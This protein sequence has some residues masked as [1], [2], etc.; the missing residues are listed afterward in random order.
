M[1]P[2]ILRCLLWAMTMP[3]FWPG[4]AQAGMPMPVLTDW[5]A[6]RLTT[7]SFFLLVFVASALA[8]RGLWNFLAKDF[9][10]LPR[11][12][13]RHSMA[14]VALVGAV[15]AI[16]LTMIAGARELLTPRAWEKARPR[17]TRTA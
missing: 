14:G 4:S 1:Q 17:C 16:V 15:L 7:V 10:R 2:R 3:L 6:L 11:L 8:V 9:P 5:A 13:Y 12:G